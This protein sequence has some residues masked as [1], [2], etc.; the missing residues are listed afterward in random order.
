MPFAVLLAA[1][2]V[3]SAPIFFVGTASRE[4]GRLD[5]AT[6]AFTSIGTTTATS[7]GLGAATSG[8]PYFVDDVSN[9]DGRFSLVYVDSE[10]LW[11]LQQGGAIQLAAYLAFLLMLARRLYRFHAIPDARQQMTQAAALAALVV[12]T[13]LSYGHFF[14]LHVQSTQ[15]PIAFWNWA[16]LGCGIAA[17]PARPVMDEEPEMEA[18]EEPAELAA[19]PQP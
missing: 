6:G 11:T 10:L 12:G 7:V 9:P 14:L 3:W 2:T 5:A 15:A 1:G 19:Q 18:D 8:S 16:I 4:F 17:L 13:A